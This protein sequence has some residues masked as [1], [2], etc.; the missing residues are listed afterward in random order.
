MIP[1]DYQIEVKPLKKA[2]VS[3]KMEKEY[4]N[5]ERTIII[6]GSYIFKRRMKKNVSLFMLY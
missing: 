1:W 2:L 6:K 5:I 4:E 3:K